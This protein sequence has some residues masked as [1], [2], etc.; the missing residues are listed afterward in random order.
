MRVRQLWSSNNDR[1]GA[2]QIR[3]DIQKTFHPSRQGLAPGT[4]TRQADG[5]F[6]RHKVDRFVRKKMAKVSCQ[7]TL[8]SGSQTW[9][10]R[11]RTVS[12]TDRWEQGAVISQKCRDV[13][14]DGAC[15]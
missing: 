5:Q 4:H 11:T 10:G 3:L 7:S 8:W 6:F 2:E 15:G 1:I 14:V 13:V 12:Q 9:Y